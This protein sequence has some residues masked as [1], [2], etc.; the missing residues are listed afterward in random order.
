MPQFLSSTGCDV[1]LSMMADHIRTGRYSASEVV[2]IFADSHSENDY[3]QLNLSDSDVESSG[4][5]EHNDFE[6]QEASSDDSNNE[7]SAEVYSD[8]DMLSADKVC[9]LSSAFILVL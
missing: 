7:K 9:I 6:S 3:F 1:C 5:S 8:M 2:D 4:S